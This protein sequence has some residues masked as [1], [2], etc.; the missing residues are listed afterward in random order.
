MTN[1]RR[2]LGSALVPAVQ[3][4]LRALGLGGY[5]SLASTI[6][7]LE[8]W[9]PGSLSYRLN[10]PGNLKYA[11]Q[12]GAVPS[13]IAGPDGIPF[14]QFSTYDAGEAALERQ[15]A[16]DAS[17]GLSISAFAKKYAPA[18]DAN[19]PVSY[20]AHLAAARGLSVDAPLSFAADA[21][22]SALTGGSF[23]GG[24]SWA[25]LSDLFPQSSG[26]G[27]V[28]PALIAAGAVLLGLGILAVV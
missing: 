28:D 27:S 6:Q 24:S 7:T 3:V 23:L 2:L 10:N 21:G 4:G 12:A 17:R 8:G 9:Y 20:A 18:E 11:G 26:N 16:L 19:D 13:S 5:S 1:G 15:I 22:D 14:A 25:P